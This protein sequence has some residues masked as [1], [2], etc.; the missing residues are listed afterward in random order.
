MPEFTTTPEPALEEL[1][2]DPVIHAV[3]DR[4]GVRPDE[5]LAVLRGVR[6]AR[7]PRAAGPNARVAAA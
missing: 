3:M 4:D 5:V 1:L 2:G 6:E 7:R